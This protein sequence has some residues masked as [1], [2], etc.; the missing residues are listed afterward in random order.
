MTPAETFRLLQQEGFLFQS[1]LTQGLTALRQASD[2]DSQKGNYY[3][4]FFQLSIGLERLM[5]TTV[6]VHHIWQNNL[7]MPSNDSLRQLGHRLRA[8][9][10]HLQALNAIDDNPLDV[11]PDDSIS[12]DILDVLD[13]FARTSRYYNLDTLVNGT[14]ACDPID[15]YKRVLQRIL[16]ED[17]AE[18]VV[19]RTIERQCA[20]A[21]G[22]SHTSIAVDPAEPHQSS[23]QILTRML[24]DPA[25]QEL[26]SRHAVYH[27][28]VIVSALKKLIEQ[29]VDS[30]HLLAQRL[31][32]TQI[33]VPY[34]YEF[35]DFAWTDKSYVLRKKR[36]P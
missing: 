26:A 30:A 23:D 17:I 9:Y 12:F 36:W 19:A 4:A 35:L 18:K 34:M 20:I 1:C 16:D 22:M 31:G 2:A 3:V 33:S 10:S 8:L 21:S 13:S 11:V 15:D 5:K 32:Q 28:L 14:T 27:V 6:I 25:L 24:V 7:T 29:V